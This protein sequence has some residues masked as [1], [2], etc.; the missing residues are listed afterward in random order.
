MWFYTPSTKQHQQAWVG[1]ISTST[2]PAEMSSFEFIRHVELEDIHSSH[3]LAD[4]NTLT[5]KL[6]FQIDATLVYPVVQ[7]IDPGTVAEGAGL[8]RT[9]VSGSFLGLVYGLAIRDAAEPIIKTINFSSDSFFAWL[10]QNATRATYDATLFTDRVEVLEPWRDS[11][12]IPEVGTVNWLVKANV[13]MQGTLHAIEPMALFSLTFDEPISLN[14]CIQWCVGLEQLFGFLIGHRGVFPV[15]NVYLSTE[16]G[17]EAPPPHGSLQLSGMNWREEA[18]PHRM[19]CI[20]LFGRGGGDLETI[21]VNFYKNPEALISKIKAVELTRFFTRDLVE[22][23]KVIVPA[24]EQCLKERFMHPDE[25]SY[26]GAKQAFLDWIEA[27]ENSDIREFSR[28]HVDFKEEKAPGLKTQ[29]ARAIDYL[30]GRGFN[31]PREL[32]SSLPKRR[33]RLV[34]KVAVLREE[35]I[36]PLTNE[37]EAATMMLMLFIFDDL[38]IDIEALSKNYFGWRGFT[39]FLRSK[40]M[41]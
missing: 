2:R 14:G 21:L 11:A 30:N 20:H 7:T 12:L 33:G 23:F 25:T 19:N 4:A 3:H 27:A 41:V 29:V 8:N 22:R 1:Q 10:G 24:L 18:T 17:S 37:I 36:N 38:G 6:D 15:F 40:D 39:Q 13:S 34:H 35:D 26:L 16:L 9:I 5:G 32:S 31:F 28:K